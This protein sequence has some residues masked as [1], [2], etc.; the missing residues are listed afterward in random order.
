MPAQ[1]LIVDDEP[2][3][4]DVLS[5]LLIRDGYSV[6]IAR[7][8]AEAL[9]SVAKQK[10]DLILLD[11][12]MPFVDGFTVC[13]TLKNDVQTALI[14]ITMLTG[15]DDFEHRKRGMEVGADD[16]LAKPFEQSMLKAR[17]QSQLRIK[18]LT[19]QLEHTESVIFMLALA[20]EEKDSYTEG[21]LR[22]LKYYSEQLA[23][24]CGLEDD[25]VQAVSYGGI[26]HDIGKIGVSEAILTKPDALTSDERLQMEKHP[27]IGARIVSQM[28]FASK[29]EP[30]V[31]HHHE[32]W[33]GRGYP[34]SIG[35]A[36]IPIGAR[37]VAIADS[38]DAMTTD[39][40]YRAAL[41][42]EE[43]IARLDAGAGTQWDPVLVEQFV[44]LIRRNGLHLPH[45]YA[46]E[47]V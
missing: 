24:A 7:N 32:R 17:I 10:P 8:G 27:E 42:Q 18:R 25:C 6:T 39:R 37:I 23:R 11:V 26:L 45:S 21:H 13:Q 34:D 15:Q 5:R 19:D 20:I 41:S 40:P 31:R 29:V 1:I 43:S 47:V 9:A 16:F 36:S 35:G 38:Y 30:I 33:D 14:P 22:R 46:K 12:M 28:R 2:A 44:T 3:I 4:I